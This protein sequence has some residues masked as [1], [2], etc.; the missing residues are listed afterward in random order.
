M[1]VGPLS[2]ALDD[3]HFKYPCA[4]LKPIKVLLPFNWFNMERDFN[5]IQSSMHDNGRFCT[6]S[7]DGEYD[8]IRV[9]LMWWCSFL[10]RKH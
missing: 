2:L 4:C 3:D 5:S 9:R 1:M 10:L 8:E 6:I 7:M